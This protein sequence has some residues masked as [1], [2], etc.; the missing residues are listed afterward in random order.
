MQP[1]R[2]DAALLSDVLQFAGEVQVLVARIAPQDYLQ[3]LATRRAIERCVEL[4][5]KRRIMSAK[6]SA[7]PIPRSHGARSSPSDTGSFT[8]IATSIL[9]ASATWSIAACPLS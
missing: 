3:D 2:R 1:D 5:G 4:I 8:G 9:S 6:V 7:T